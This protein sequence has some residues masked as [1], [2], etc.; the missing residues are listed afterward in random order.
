V[1]TKVGPQLVSIEW[2][3]PDLDELH[4]LVQDRL[5]ALRV[6]DLNVAPD[7]RTWHSVLEWASERLGKLE[8][9]RK[10]L[11]ISIEVEH[12]LCNL[13]TTE[14]EQRAELQREVSLAADVQRCFVPRAAAVEYPGLGLSSFY[15]PADSCGGDWWSAYDLP[16]D[17]VMIV[18][19]DVTGHGVAPA[20]MTG[21]AKGAADVIVRKTPAKHLTPA[22][23]LE[24]LNLSICTA[25]NDSLMMTCAVAVIDPCASTV[26]F[27]SAGHP[28]PYV[29]RS[30]NGERT[31]K[32]LVANGN[33][34][35]ASV[36]TEYENSSMGLDVG[37]AI[38]WYTDGVLDTENER[39]EAFGE[40]RLRHVLRYGGSIA[41][42]DL[43][44]TLWGAM[45][46]FMGKAAPVDDIT[47]VTARFGKP[48][49]RSR[50]MSTQ[51]G[52]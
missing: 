6:D 20:M 39:G 37:D 29:V 13:V 28:L 34:L 10:R 32:Q 38:I 12:E 43:R 35:G 15:R 41:P 8:E 18:I 22:A 45:F 9:D 2:R 27:A 26:T 48:P 44:E 23:M 25:G 30:S 17:K 42:S 1:S 4:P 19:G 24:D 14:R 51:R 46:E 52:A 16:A 11:A 50:R 33:P 7:T 31:L 36:Q 21:V 5:R 47:F 49:T 40:R 3:K